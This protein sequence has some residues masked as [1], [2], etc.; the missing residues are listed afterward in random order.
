MVELRQSWE[1]KYQ[2]EKWFSVPAE[3]VETFEG[4][5]FL[6]IRPTCQTI[7]RLVTKSTE[8]NQSLTASSQ[9]QTMV[10]DRNEA[11]VKKLS[12]GDTETLDLFESGAASSEPMNNAKKRKVN[13]GEYTVNISVA[14]KTVEVLMRG[15]R[16]TRSDLMVRMDP[17]QLE[18]VFQVLGEDSAECLAAS[19]RQYN[20]KQDGSKS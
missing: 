6:R 11:A 10:Q 16:P 2:E 15:N 3:M 19:K 17:A 13:A 5:A 7:C 14:E 12:E 4:N 8:K 9:L 18:V 20:K 1:I